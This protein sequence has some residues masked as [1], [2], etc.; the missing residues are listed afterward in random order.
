MRPG[1]DVAVRSKP[2]GLARF[3]FLQGFGVARRILSFLDFRKQ[4]TPRSH[5]GRRSRVQAVADRLAAGLAK[6]ERI[7]HDFGET[8]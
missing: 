2:A 6:A 8:N 4:V 1:L 5:G 3:A 7:V